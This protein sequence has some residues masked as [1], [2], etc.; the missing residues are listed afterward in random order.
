MIRKNNKVATREY[1]E[2][3]KWNKIFNTRVGN[4]ELI[5]KGL[6]MNPLNIERRTGD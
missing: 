1:F 3:K 2:K 5:K 4:Y 6:K